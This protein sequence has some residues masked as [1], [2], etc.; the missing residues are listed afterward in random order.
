MILTDKSTAV[1]IAL[2][3]DSNHLKDCL[4]VW[5]ASCVTYQYGSELILVD[6]GGDEATRLI[7]EEFMHDFRN[8]GIKIVFIPKK[9]K[10][11]TPTR[12]GTAFNQGLEFVDARYTLFAVGSM[13]PNGKILDEYKRN[14]DEDNVL[15]GTVDHIK[16]PYDYSLMAREFMTGD[17][18]YRVIEQSPTPWDC[19]GESNFVVMTKLAQEL[20]FSGTARQDFEATIDFALRLNAIKANFRSVPDAKMFNVTRSPSS[21]RVRKT[22]SDS[23][24]LISKVGGRYATSNANGNS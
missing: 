23:K 10:S 9:T 7:A 1:V 21:M 4:H 14:L 3:D 11:K 12:L 22:T 19:F 20:G 15:I 17:Q 16:A 6:R 8:A 18:S 2:N 24:L 5:A 13:Y